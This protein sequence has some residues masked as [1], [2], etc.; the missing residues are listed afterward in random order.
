MTYAEFTEITTERLHLRALRRGDAQDYFDRLGS[1]EAVTRGMLW[2]P[3]EDI[4]QSV[5]SIE[6][7][8]RRYEE[9]KCYRWGI[10]LK[11]D[12]R[13]IG[14]IELLAFEEER[15]KCGFAY[16]LG[17][18]F[19]GRGY[20]T[21]ALRS[22]LDFAFTRLEVKRV[23][24]DHFTTNPASG[25]VMRKVGMKY[26]GTIQEKYEK[27]GKKLDADQYSVTKEEFYA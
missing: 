3:H 1:S 2:E 9:G 23:E 12:E 25:A 17:K 8:L 22:A 4:S 26:M 27:Q 6:K 5:A 18:D 16:M 19:W 13:I 10:A 14:V 7:A 20:G 24:A 15:D 11:E 21:E